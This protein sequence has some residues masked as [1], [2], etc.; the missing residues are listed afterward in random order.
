M[1][2]VGPFR[3]GEGFRNRV[4]SVLDCWIERDPVEWRLGEWSGAD[5][6]IFGLQHSVFVEHLL[7]VTNDL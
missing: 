4:R 3:S 2:T 6:A 1:Y 7:I 5:T